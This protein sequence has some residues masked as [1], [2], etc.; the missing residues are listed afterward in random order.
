MSASTSTDPAWPP[1]P[2]LAAYAELLA[3]AVPRA[4][5]FA[6][7]ASDG[8]VISDGDLPTSELSM[9]S[10]RIAAE[11]CVPD[12][13][14]EYE[15]ADGSRN[16]ILP[17]RTDDRLVSWCIASFADP[18][19][20]PGRLELIERLMAPALGVLVDDLA[21]REATVA[22]NN[23]SAALE[24]RLRT[25][26]GLDDAML[27]TPHG[28]AGLG[29]LVAAVAK[30]LRVGYS[31]L[32]M[33]DKRIRF[34][35]T[36]PSWGKVDRRAL[37]G[38]A[39]RRLLPAVS[40]RTTALVLDV[41]RAPPELPQHQD[42]YQI[43]ASPIREGGK[44]VVGV[45]ALF[46]QV[47]NQQYR[48]ADMAFADHVA[49]R[50][51]RVVELNYDP[52]TGLM[53]RSGFE[54]QL[55]DAYE[56]LDSLVTEH[57]LVFFDLDNMALFNDTFDHRAGDEVLVRF[58][59]ELSRSL[60]ERG[61][62]SRLAGDNFA[63]LLPETDVSTA[64]SFAERIRLATHKM[65]YLK[66]DKSHQITVSAGVAPLRRSDE[67]PAAAMISPKVAC[68]A[69]K[70][71]GRDRVEVYDQENHSIIRRVDD[72]Q[73]VGQIHNAL[74][75]GDFQLVAQPIV[76]LGPT[77]NAHF[78]YY[79][80]LVRMLDSQGRELKPGDFFSAAERYQLMPQLD[81]FVVERS[82]ELIAEHRELIEQSDARFAINLSGQS[83]QDDSLLEF[84]VGT[85]NRFEVPA[86]NLCFEIT[87][88]AAVA[89]MSSA[90][91]FIHSLKSLGAI[92]SLDDFG[93]GLSSFAY[94]KSF[95]VDA[96][97]IDGGFVHDLTTNKVSEAMVVAITHVAQVMKLTTIAEYVE[98]EAARRR[99]LE[100]GVDYA[101][102]YLVGEPRSLADVL[103]SEI[104]AAKTDVGA[105]VQKG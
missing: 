83:L 92:F 17:M 7:L 28:Q 45:L 96:V 16:V 62:A 23:G 8:R 65:S 21:Y 51:E 68:T 56:Q 76:P 44:R 74:N 38:V 85:I 77:A 67:G 101:Q 99:L 18:D 69:A 32:V 73:I 70:D 46:G 72:M 78:P 57:A 60:P 93:A 5:G 37:D 19:H 3:S 43:I 31:V 20:A 40:S 34:S 14:S 33:P 79:E 84:V 80:I 87:E 94:L 59:A 26:Y 91:R 53:N 63:V 66:G 49:R 75:S 2:T 24:R 82:L 48:A 103:K 97:K 105:A 102:G 98:D 4:R 39:A 88:T 13:P 52:M 95:N 22:M 89:N 42:G 81:R 64:V 104:A 90:Q 12:A 15:G 1:A 61:V 47:E 55:H 6:V 50:T 27:N 41:T 36:H 71:H 29:G 11:H 30:D 25:I 35:V 100:I 54:S 58:A 9:I 86:K 10:R